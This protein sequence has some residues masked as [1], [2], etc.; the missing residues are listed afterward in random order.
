MKIKGFVLVIIIHWVSLEG[1]AQY[2]GG[3][4]KGEG[5]ATINGLPIAGGSLQGLYSGGSGQGTMVAT[6]FS[7]SIDGYELA[8]MYSG[9][10]GKGDV[11]VSGFAQ[12]LDGQDLNVLFT[13]NAGRG[14]QVGTKTSFSLGG[15]SSDMIYY[16]GTGRGD[17]AAASFQNA[18]FD[19][20][21][22]NIWS[23]RIST[24]WELPENWGCNQ[25]PGINAV[26][27]IP[28]G[29]PR[30]PVVNANTEIRQIQIA[31]GASVLVKASV[32]LKLNGQ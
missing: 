10:G 15:E 28:S 22:Q 8:A 13:G 30:F 18:L 12:S 11:V 14:D 3:A 20:S 2:S 27:I 5:T 25:V 16:G 4:G 9:G 21:V 6:G 31:T 17:S 26:V 1:K 32:W 24:D 19:C 23:G 29:V 7:I